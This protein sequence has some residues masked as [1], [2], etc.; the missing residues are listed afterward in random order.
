M[1]NT[2]R[3]CYFK[4]WES[5]VIFQLPDQIWSDRADF[6]RQQFSIWGLQRLLRFTNGSDQTCVIGERL[7][8]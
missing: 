8:R 2:L 7:G 6:I 3:G 5:A 1:N 4:T